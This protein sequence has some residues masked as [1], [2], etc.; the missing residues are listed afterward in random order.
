[1]KRKTLAAMP[2]I[3]MA[4][5]LSAQS[6]D[7]VIPSLIKAIPQDVLTGPESV[8]PIDGGYEYRGMTMAFEDE[9]R[10]IIPWLRE[11]SSGR[12][13]AR[14]DFPENLDVVD[15][16]TGDTL[17]RMTHSGAFAMVYGDVKLDHVVSLD[18]LELGVD[19]R[20]DVEDEDFWATARM[21]GLESTHEVANGY[22]TFLGQMDGVEFSS[23]MPAVSGGSSSSAT[24]ISGVSVSTSFPAA[25]LDPD[26]MPS[27][28]RAY[29]LDPWQVAFK[30]EGSQGV[31]K[32][33][34][35]EEMK[36]T[37]RVGKNSFMAKM[38]AGSLVLASSFKDQH[39]YIEG[40]PLLG[41]AGEVALQLGQLDLSLPVAPGP[42]GDTL[43][44]DLKLS[45]ISISDSLWDMFDNSGALSREPVSLNVVM[46]VPVR[47]DMAL[48]ELQ[49]LLRDDD[50]AGLQAYMKDMDLGKIQVEKL[51]INALGVS[52]SMQG[53]IYGDA[54]ISTLEGNPVTRPDW[55]EL[56]LRVSGADSLMSGL[57]ASGLAPE[58][59][60][61]VGAMMLEMYSESAGDDI[62]KSTI[63]M[64]G[65]QI[66]VNDQRVR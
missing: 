53:S 63:K 11:V 13:T 8:H 36:V 48:A 15:S 44:I 33:D 55:G 17:A 42:G 50:P 45:N 12:D 32:V 59:M 64:T 10:L 38:T 61:N 62:R 66:L 24:E 43:S 37:S 65:D 41:G 30:A 54:L 2:F 57:Q 23:E 35:G 25:L 14:I 49:D 56:S 22:S 34:L 60:I 52:F 40:L 51:D 1:M 47:N 26:L 7:D 29:L 3:L 31:S 9:A 19:I 4:G 6:P 21:T 58:P 46:S 16:K 5:S 28:G 27:E 39:T 20:L 18:A